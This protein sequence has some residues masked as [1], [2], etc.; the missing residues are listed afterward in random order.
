MATTKFSALTA[1]AKASL[2]GAA[3]IPIVDTGLSAPKN[4]KVLVSDFG[5]TNPTDKYIPRNN[6]GVLDDSYIKQE[7]GR[8]EI[9]AGVK[10]YY[11][12]LENTATTIDDD[13]S[14][15]DVPTGILDLDSDNS[16]PTIRHLGLNNG[17]LDNQEVL[18]IWHGSNGG[19]L[20]NTGNL[21]L[22]AD[23]VPTTD[24]EALKLIWDGAA[25]KWRE[26]W[27]YPYRAPSNPPASASATGIK[28]TVTWDSS[29]IY[30]CIAT[31]TWKRVAIATW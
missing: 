15:T 29:Y 1:I 5:G 31:D 8:I 26:L 18:I 7:S 12:A 21:L 27:R 14:T 23:W 4:R 30:V 3:Y 25:S 10:P 2:T 24:G 17:T 11:I 28:G 13:V 20:E 19:T 9:A 16:D 22:S 6:S